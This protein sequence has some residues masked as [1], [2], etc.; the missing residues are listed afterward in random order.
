MNNLLESDNNGAMKTP[1]LKQHLS[2][3]VKL[4]SN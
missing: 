3:L 2:Y 4:C 1:G